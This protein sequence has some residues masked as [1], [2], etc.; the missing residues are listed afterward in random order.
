MST[1]VKIC[2]ITRAADARAAV[3]AGADALGFVF[4]PRSPRA[5]TVEQAE[6]IVRDLPTTVTTVGVFVNESVA[7]IARVVA[8]IGLRAVQL[9][10]DEPVEQCTALPCPCIKAVAVS[11]ALDADSLSRWPAGVLLLLDVHDQERR[12]GT[13]ATVDWDA[14]ARIAR[15]RPVMLAGGLRPEN[16]EDAIARVAPYAVDV[17]SGVEDGPGLKNAARIRELMDAVARADA[18]KWR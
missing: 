10:G 6:R 11:P 2:G 12:G 8:A 14:A 7:E 5:V 13:G 18:R 15:V 16:V 17:S 9:H 3:D 4:W 1:R